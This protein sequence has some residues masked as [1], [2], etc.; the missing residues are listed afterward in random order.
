[1]SAPLEQGETFKF[2]QSVYDSGGALANAGT[3]TA[4]ITLP[5]GTTSSPSITNPETGQYDLDYLTSQVGRHTI[6]GTAT[7]GTLGA[8]VEKFDSVFHVE[9][10]GR[11]LISVDDARDHLRAQNTIKAN[12]D[13]EQLRLLCFGAS[14][15]IE[16]DLGRIIGRRLITETHDGG[17][18]YLTIDSRPLLSVSSIVE[19]GVTLTANDY[20]VDLTSQI[21]WRGT[22]TS[23]MRWRR[24][25]Q[26]VVL[27]GVAGMVSTPI[28]ARLVA[29]YVVQ[30]LWQSSQQR[31]HPAFDEGGADEVTVSAAAVLSGLP[32]PLLRAYDRLRISL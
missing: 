12:A 22:Q 30:S 25:V 24:G 17:D 10:P 31:P 32:A 5:D 26:N 23:R 2:R 15:A 21:V 27:S 1:M 20:V 28:T 9:P 4:T 18:Y 13:L 8:G 7:G 19:A 11:Y 14:E 3:V 29:H 16:L 6:I